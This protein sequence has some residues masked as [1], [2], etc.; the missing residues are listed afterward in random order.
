VKL[1]ASH[2]EARGNPL[3]R[4]VLASFSTAKDG[5]LSQQD[6]VAA[7]CVLSSRGSKANKARTAFQAGP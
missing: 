5:T 7:C 3:A 1:A 2:G 6:W 4:R